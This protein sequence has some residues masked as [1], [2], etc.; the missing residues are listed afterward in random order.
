M[1]GFSDYASLLRQLEELKR[2][3]EQADERAQ[4]ADKRAQEEQK[5]RQEADKRTQ[6][7]LKRAL[8][9]ENK[10]KTT[11]LEFLRYCH[12]YTCEPMVVEIRKRKSTSGKTVNPRG[13]FYPTKLLPWG[14]FESMQHETFQRLLAIFH[15]ESQP[16]A[17]LFDERAT[18]QSNGRKLCRKKL[19]SEEDLRLY[20]E[21]AV[22]HPAI[23]IIDAL[24]EMPQKEWNVA[25]GIEFINHH[26]PLN[27]ENKEAE[28]STVGEARLRTELRQLQSADEKFP[29]QRTDILCVH[30]LSEDVWIQKLVAE[31]KAPHKVS[32]IDLKRALKNENL[33]PE[34]A[35]R[36]EF[37]RFGDEKDQESAEDMIA[38][39]IT[40]TFHY[41]IGTR[42][43]YGYIS[44]GEAFV[45]LRFDQEKPETLYYHL[46]VPK[47]KVEHP[48]D[49]FF[50]A[51]CQV[52]CF[53]LMALKSE[54]LSDRW[55]QGIVKNKKLPKWPHTRDQLIDTTTD[56]D[57]GPSPAASDSTYDL[58]T[59]TNTH[60]S[61]YGLRS[62]ARS[63]CREE[64]V[65]VIEDETDSEQDDTEDNESYMLS[66][67]PPQTMEPS[68]K[69]RR[70]PQGSGGEGSGNREQ[71]TQ[72]RQYCT[73]TCLLG[74][75]RG[76]SL[77]EKCPNVSSH[78]IGPNE[79]K[80][81]V[82]VE[83]FARLIREQLG[84]ST[85][86]GCRYLD[87]IGARGAL[88]RLVLKRYG[89]TFVGKGTVSVFIPDLLHE[90]QVYQQLERLQGLVVP[91]YLGNINL[92]QCYFLDPEVYIVHMMLMSWG[93]KE[94]DEADVP[95]IEEEVKRSFAELR[96]EGV[97]HGDK[98]EP[99]MLWNE[100]RQR[101]MV[102]DFDRARILPARH[103][104]VLKV[105]NGKRKREELWNGGAG[106]RVRCQYI[107]D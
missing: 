23:D 20:L 39:I 10:D 85:T 77:D 4:E 54:L 55:R 11:L 25:D 76:W 12:I 74:L 67:G 38:Q 91:V 13:R 98:R 1:S 75:K 103:K 5:Q 64:E 62:K 2:R 49:V 9:A 82:D 72:R 26:N 79:T 45:F 3:A 19:A 46:V 30:K 101:V 71:P 58:P 33:C 35:F 24:K 51:V 65:E 66:K 16:A 69:R 18:I 37:Y 63:T 92:I 44:T 52:A 106:K 93:G 81:P 21:F 96:Q 42:V 41:M 14:N 7:A 104:Q 86:R 83:T 47:D 57:R 28:A 15:P 100:E 53:C 27:Q 29:H 80:H 102:V 94:A 6:Q 88:F 17:Q 95:N 60:P 48:S 8:E 61:E 31:H 68:N 70:L 97:V 99:N 32:P 105:L 84:R 59:P 43:R 56:E 40:Q 107:L 90:G 36:Y 34:V 87:K 22:Q 50:T 73:Q 78:R 89:Y